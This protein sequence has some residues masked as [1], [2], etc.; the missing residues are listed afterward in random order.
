MW[1]KYNQIRREYACLHA[2]DTADSC[3]TQTRLFLQ[4]VY[5]VIITGTSAHELPVLQIAGG[6][7]T[8][9]QAEANHE[10]P[11]TGEP[12]PVTKSEWRT[13]RIRSKFLL[14]RPKL[15]VER[16]WSLP[17]WFFRSGSVRRLRE[18]SKDLKSRVSTSTEPRTIQ[19]NYQSRP[20]VLRSSY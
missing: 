3:V 7:G 4:L 10:E 8:V 15:L 1:S 9:P 6:S 14:T 12:V 5:Y 17:S 19:A 20:S 16:R 11:Q 18:T 13:C 2:C